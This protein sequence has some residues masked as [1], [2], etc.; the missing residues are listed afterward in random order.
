MRTLN[1]PTMEQMK[2]YLELHPEL[3]NSE[4]M[5]L[6]E[7]DFLLEIE[8]NG[9]WGTNK[10]GCLSFVKKVIAPG[11]YIV[12]GKGTKNIG[13]KE[14]QKWVLDSEYDNDERFN[15]EHIAVIGNIDGKIYLN[16][17]KS[18][19]E[20]GDFYRYLN[21]Y[22]FLDESIEEYLRTKKVDYDFNPYKW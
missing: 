17:F 5:N 16:W 3:K 4:Y 10:K 15:F 12:K 7:G 8:G 11:L 9:H 19:Y 6:K 13:T 22:V 18:V 1:I 21:G 20:N 14:E 2:K